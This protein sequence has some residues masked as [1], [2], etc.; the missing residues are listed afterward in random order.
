MTSC[1]EWTGV[2]L[3]TL[4]K[5]A[6]LKGSATWFVAEGAEEVKGASSMPIAKAM[7]DCL[8][9]YGMNGEALRPQQGFPVR[10]MSTSLCGSAASTPVSRPT[11]V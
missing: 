10:L 1:S 4:L 11:L 3:S 7:D 8:I 6:G 2:L 5:E 9:A